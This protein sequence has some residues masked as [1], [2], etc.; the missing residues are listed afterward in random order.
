MHRFAASVVSVIVERHVE[1]RRAILLQERTK[2]TAGRFWGTLEVPQGRLLEGESLADAAAREV[3][4]EAGLLDFELSTPS[5]GSTT[6][7]EQLEAFCGFC[8]R[9]RGAHDFLALCVVGSAKG[10]PRST[11]EAT[12]PRWCSKDE[13]NAAIAQGR[14]F[15]LNVPMLKWYWQELPSDA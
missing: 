10:T 9:E 5:S 13:V 6:D 12:N 4:E 8:V 7:S 2:S 11:E 14:V 15:P 1:G 3:K